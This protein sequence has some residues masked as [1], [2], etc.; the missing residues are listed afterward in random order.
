MSGVCVCVCVCVCVYTH[1]CVSHFVA[2][3]SPRSKWWE[4][5]KQYDTDKE[6]LDMTL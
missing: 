1:T 4:F 3:Y 6:N 5:Q 2:V